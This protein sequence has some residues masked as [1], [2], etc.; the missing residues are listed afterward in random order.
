[1]ETLSFR[2]WRL[3]RKCY[4]FVIVLLHRPSPKIHLTAED[5]YRSWKQRGKTSLMIFRL[6]FP[7]VIKP[8]HFSLSYI[9]TICLWA[10]HSPHLFCSQLSPFYPT[11]VLQKFT[12]SQK[13]KLQSSTIHQ[14]PVTMRQLKL[15]LGSAG[16]KQIRDE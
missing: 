7:Q 10:P 8:P 13:L 5:L 3:R 15:D 1:M 6:A 12:R 9:S 14:S 2:L 16:P 4:I 11:A